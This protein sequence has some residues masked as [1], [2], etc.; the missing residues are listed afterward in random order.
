MVIVEIAGGEACQGLA[1]ERIRGGRSGFDDVALVKFEL[2]FTGYIFLGGLY[3]CLYSV[4]K[5]SKPFSFV[6]DLSQLILIYL[7]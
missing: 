3:E 5:R 1:V 4:A 6:N 7:I 2:N